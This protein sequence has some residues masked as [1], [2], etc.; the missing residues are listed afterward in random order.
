MKIKSLELPL[1]NMID[2]FIRRE[3]TQTVRGTLG[4]CHMTVK[5]K[6]RIM[7]PQARKHVEPLET[8]KARKDP[9]YKASE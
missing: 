6:I 9:P 1:F 5:T 3:E 4:E 8:E 7:L 2:V